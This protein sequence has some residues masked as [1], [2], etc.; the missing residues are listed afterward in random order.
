[1]VQEVVFLSTNTIPTMLE[2]YIL[3]LEKCHSARDHQD[4]NPY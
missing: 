1:M 3:K 4:L 2:E